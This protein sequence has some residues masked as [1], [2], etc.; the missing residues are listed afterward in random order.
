[1]VNKLKNIL[2]IFLAFNLNSNDFP[3]EGQNN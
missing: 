1:M 2:L 3:E